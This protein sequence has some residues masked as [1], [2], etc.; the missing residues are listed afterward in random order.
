MTDLNAAPLAESVIRESRWL[1]PGEANPSASIVDDLMKS[2]AVP[3]PLVLAAVAHALE[4]VEATAV[5]R[6]GRVDATADV[7]RDWLGKLS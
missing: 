7:L 4:H 2:G 5:L 1:S 6:S 3:T